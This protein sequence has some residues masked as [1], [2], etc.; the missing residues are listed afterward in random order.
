[1]DRDVI[2]NI[3]LTR[4][5][6]METQGPTLPVSVPEPAEVFAPPADGRYVDVGFFP[7]ANKW[8]GMTQGRMEQGLLGVTVVWP[9]NKGVIKPYA[10]AK[11][12]AQHFPKGLE[13]S[14]DGVKVKINRDPV[15]AEPLI[16]ATK[17]SVPVNISWEATRVS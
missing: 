14:A 8:E 10:A 4:A 3:L 12:V 16:E 11:A 7:N 5:L 17:V 13:L 1:M 6:L 2:A 9:K 15:L